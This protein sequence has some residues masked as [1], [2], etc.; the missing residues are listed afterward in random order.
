MIQS[1]NCLSLPITPSANSQLLYI[2]KIIP[3]RASDFFRT[4]RSPSAPQIPVIPII[5][6][7][8]GKSIASTDGTRFFCVTVLPNEKSSCASVLM[9]ETTKMRDTHDLSLL[10]RLDRSRHRTLLIER[11]VRSRLVI[12]P[13]VGFQHPSQ[14]PFIENDDVIQALSPD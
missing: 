2:T 13:G 4:Y 10:W 5:I 6:G 8:H 7:E 12:I 3:R 14:M 1:L 9:M 11:Q